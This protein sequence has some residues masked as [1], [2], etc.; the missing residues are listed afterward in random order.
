MAP[1][2]CLPRCRPRG[3]VHRRGRARH[4]P[5][6]PP[7]P[8]RGPGFPSVARRC[9]PERTAAARA[10]PPARGTRGPDHRAQPR[11]RARATQRGPE[12]P[13]ASALGFPR[14]RARRRP[15]GP[16]AGHSAAAGKGPRSPVR[17]GP[18]EPPPPGPRRRPRHPAPSPFRPS[19]EG[20][21]RARLREGPCRAPLPPGTRA[22]D[23]ARNAE[24]RAELGRTRAARQGGPHA[25]RRPAFGGAGRS[26]ERARRP[27]PARAPALRRG[28]TGG[29]PAQ[30]RGCGA[31][32]GRGG[33]GGRKPPRRRPARHASRP[34]RDARCSAGRAPPARTVTGARGALGRAQ[35]LFPSPPSFRFRPAPGGAA[36]PWSL[37]LWGLRRAAKGKGV[38]PPG[39]AGAGG[40]GPSVRTE[41]ACASRRRAPP[42]QPGS[43]HTH[44][45]AAAAARRRPDAR[46]GPPRRRTRPAP[47][48]HRP[49]RPGPSRAAPTRGS[50]IADEGTAARP[51]ARPAA[52][53]RRRRGRGAAG[54][55]AAR[56]GAWGGERRHA[57]GTPLAAAADPGGRPFPRRRG[58]GAGTAAQ[59][60]R[61]SDGARGFASLSLSLG[62]LF[63]FWPGARA[64]V[65]RHSASRSTRR[66]RGARERGSAGADP[67]PPTK[68][69]KNPP[70]RPVAGE[71]PAAGEV[72]PSGAPLAG[73]ER[74]KPGASP[75]RAARKAPDVL[76]EAAT[77]RGGRGPDTEAPFQPGRGSLCSRRRNGKGACGPGS[78]PPASSRTAARRCSRPAPTR[79]LPG[80]GPAPAPRVVFSRTPEGSR[81]HAA[82]T[83]LGTVK[84]PFPRPAGGATPRLRREANWKGDRPARAPDPPRRGFPATEKP[85][86]ESRPAGGP[87]RRHPKSHIDQP[88]LRADGDKGPTA[89]LPGTTTATAAQPTCPSARS[90]ASAAEERGGC[91]HPP[92]R[93]RQRRDWSGPGRTRPSVRE[94]VPPT[95]RGHGPPAGF[96]PASRRSACPAGTKK[97]G[98]RHDKR[99]R[100]TE[101]RSQ[102][103]VLA[104]GATGPGARSGG[105]E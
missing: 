96:R 9:A 79:A 22:A 11:A 47:N 105:A 3:S 20:R 41:R 56:R 32:Y 87:L 61:H 59:L 13:E 28:R 85:R 23:L 53:G 44:G 30:G 15:L 58:Q 2:G 98:G 89:T 54:R 33:G 83:Q 99:K 70:R 21:G 104:T 73:S 64:P 26:G 34:G 29:R 12:R 37:S 8:S 93:S 74:P 88:R 36:R 1:P 6:P 66:A 101:A 102:R 97:A 39:P 52:T 51:A 67:P 14:P 17:E 86:K 49:A 100:H 60:F 57:R 50:G 62:S 7:R 91:R 82:V 103:P 43:R 46:R 48:P 55:M 92:A 81:G 18:E 69:E 5:P 72:G 76:E 90:L 35:R 25:R 27:A 63:F 38:W 71:R 42:D 10:A 31:V 75:H 45:G 24:E 40:R 65:L 95:W 4:L 84:T 68:A 77:R 80:P 19:G 16:R 94:K 78:G